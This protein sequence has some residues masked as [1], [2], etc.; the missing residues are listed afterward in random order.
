MTSFA[1]VA[2]LIPLLS[3]SGV[4]AIANRT[5]VTAGVGGMLF[6]TLIG[7]GVLP[8]LYYV[9]GKISDGKKLLRDETDEPFSEKFEHAVSS[10]DE[11]G[12]GPA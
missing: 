12:S 1:F 6:G 7:V 10:H 5:I 9:F 8:G 11:P 4:C 3:A 2:G